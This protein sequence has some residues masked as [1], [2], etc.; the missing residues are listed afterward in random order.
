MRTSELLLL[1]TP[2]IQPSL[3]ADPDDLTSHVN[4]FQGT[5]NGG[6]N[7]PGA[8]R[9]FGMV[10]LGPDLQD[11]N[12]D[13]YSGYLA[14]GEFSGFSMMHE[15]GTGGA[16][17][18]GTVAQL[19]LAGDDE[20]SDPLANVT[21]GRKG[22]DEA[23][24]G[25]YSARTSDDVRVELSAAARAGIYRYTFPEGSKQKKVL[26]DVSHVLPS[27][28]GQGLGQAYRGGKVSVFEDGRYEGNGVYDNGWNRSP[29]WK[30]YFCGY[31]DPKPSSSKAYVGKD[32]EDSE[33]Q[34]DG[35]A[36][37]SSGDTR[38]GAVFSFKGDVVTS[39]V[40]ISWIS[41]EQACE[42]VQEIPE[43]TSLETVVHNAESEWT[44]KVLSKVSTTNTNKTSLSLL[45][46][47]LYFMHLIPTNQ[48]G[49]NPGWISSEPYY[50]DIFTFWDLF[51]CSTSLFHILQPKTYTEFL[52]SLIDIAKHDGYLPDARSSNYNGR[53]QG[54]S[55]ADN[56]LADA[57][58]KGIRDPSLDWTVAYSAM[59][60]DAEVAPPNTTPPDPMA[61]DSSTKEGRSA[62]P[63]WL[64]L[65]YITPKY[66]RAVSRAIEYAGNDFGLYQVADG[67]GKTAD[68]KKYLER[69]R[70]WRNHWNKKA[71]SKGF[72]GFVGPR[73]EN[74][75]FLDPGDLTA[76]GYWGDAFYEASP[77]AYSF[78]AVH[79]MA[80][81]VELMGG[82]KTA[83]KRLDAM[84]EEDD[85]GK[86]I[87][88]ATNE[89]MFNTP[90]LY[91]FI[92]SPHISTKQ[93]RAIAKQSYKDTVD[94]LPGNSDAGAMQTWLLWNMIG[95]YPLT[96]QT[97]FLIHAPWFEALTIELGGGRKLEVTA[98]GGD[99]NG[100]GAIQVQRLL[101]N[102][103][104]W[105]KS[106]LVWEDV[107]ADG[108]KLE[109]ELGEKESEWF[110][111]EGPPSPAS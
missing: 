61:P 30:I 27:H 36:S 38:V 101:V 99:G 12:T 100:G 8:A 23:S 105:K 19:P 82:E 31:F 16:P 109:F 6:N 66:S 48:T 55:N 70:H 28:R 9:P 13:A 84:F 106:W 52:R 4:L 50:Q 87:F 103:K 51:R 53:S 2:L 24:V 88:D 74:G 22:T 49:E 62:L 91:H 90:Y 92:N 54:G 73:D 20:L 45:Y 94:G 58:V 15:Q 39:R 104:E 65:G 29:E 5:E 63:D 34:D 56:I 93:S 26:V 107:F 47:S 96:G 75:T 1:L 71:E 35:V 110:N 72:E 33:E 14:K 40:G 21:V 97:T 44:S 46:S 3:Q 18:Y 83:R 42:N 102:G 111:G 77:W 57:Y 68:A 89:P 7:F 76:S 85:E 98:S 81:T 59:H 78:G 80:H 69:S 95:L 43:G 108:G 86:S 67:L 10:K 64:R 37:S 60:K 79:D 25:Y 41:A 11:G 17:K 32:G